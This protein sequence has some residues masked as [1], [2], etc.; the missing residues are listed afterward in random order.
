MTTYKIIF[1]LLLF[2]VFYTYIGYGLLLMVLIK[3]KLSFY[4]RF[5][6]KN[7]EQLPFVTLFVAAFNEQKHIVAKLENIHALDYPKDKIQILFVT[8]GSNDRSLELLLDYPHITHLHQSKRCGKLAAINRGMAHV[9]HPI[10]IYSDA[11]AMLNKEAVKEI[12]KHYNDPKVGCV[13]GEKRIIKKDIDQASGAGEG[14]YWE[15]ESLLKKLDYKLSSATGAAGE[16]FSIRTHLH[17]N[18]ENDTLLDDFMISMRIVEKGFKIAYEPKAYAT[19]TSSLSI[20]EEM[21]RKVRISAGGIQSITRLTSL[22][23]VFKFGV[24][25]IQYISHRVLRW[26]VTPFA[27]FLLLPL[28]IFLIQK[29][30]HLFYHILFLAQLLFYGLALLGWYLENRE[31]KLKLIFIP[32]YFLFMN[33]CVLKG[34]LRYLKNEQSVLWEKSLRKEL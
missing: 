22:L 16:L 26:T 27:I 29:D 20:Q 34:F 15:Y 2:L 9:K 10:V 8:D 11:N 28:N 32:Y 4:P 19:E 23:N 5:K 3:L 21:K 13:S 31:I 12:V 30:S 6:V 1:W 7:K 17:Q 25:T 18:L 14:M 33:F 24:F